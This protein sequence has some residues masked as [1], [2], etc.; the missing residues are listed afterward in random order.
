MTILQK[1]L[2]LQ[3]PNLSYIIIL[4]VQI[5]LFSDLYLIK[6]LDTSKQNRSFRVLI[7]RN[8]YVSKYEFKRKKCK[9]FN[10]Q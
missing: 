2:I 9:D 7:M 4:T 5:K 1:V 10:N 6:F 8:E 3:Q